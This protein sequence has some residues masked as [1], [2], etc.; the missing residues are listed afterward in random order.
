MGLGLRFRELGFRLRFLG[1]R[2]EDVQIGFGVYGDFPFTLSLQPSTV[3]SN[4]KPHTNPKPP[5][6]CWRS[7]GLGRL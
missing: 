7:W 1:L 6:S 5:M 4:R 2:L 3:P